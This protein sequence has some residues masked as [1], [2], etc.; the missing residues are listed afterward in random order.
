MMI[1]KVFGFLAGIFSAFGARAEGV[2]AYTVPTPP[3]LAEISTF[4]LPDAKWKN[5]A[6]GV[7]GLSYRL[8]DD[9]DAGRGRV[10]E[11]TGADTLSNG[12][13]FLNLEGPLARASCS[14]SDGSILCLMQYK[15]EALLGPD[16]P[17]TER[18]G[19]EYLLAKY[20]PGLDTERRQQV[21]RVFINEPA[22][23]VRISR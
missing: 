4:A 12:P 7:R 1:L 13:G 8:P 18:R 9:I 15:D 20:G 17:A 2:S 19:M 6:P 10:I 3:G 16:R 5:V 21:L 22:G 11:L 23:L 14:Q